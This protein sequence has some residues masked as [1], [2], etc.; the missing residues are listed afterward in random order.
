LSRAG[1][2]PQLISILAS[3]SVVYRPSSNWLI[4][5]AKRPE[6]FPTQSSAG[7][8]NSK[9]SFILMEKFRP[10]SLLPFSASNF[11]IRFDSAVKI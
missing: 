10:Q 8:W 5:K 7:K 11:S 2:F 4:V 1:F 6:N 3:S 9:P